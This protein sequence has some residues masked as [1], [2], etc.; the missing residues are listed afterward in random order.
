MVGCTAVQDSAP[1]AVV[2]A[3]ER[4]PDIFMVT[5]D[6]TNSA[7]LGSE[8]AQS[9]TPNLDQLFGESVIMPNTLTVRGITVISMPSFLSGFYPRTTKARGDVTKAWN[10]TV[11]LIQERLRQV[12]YQTFGFSS[13]FCT[14]IDFGMD[15]TGCTADPGSAYLTEEQVDGDRSLVDGL[16]SALDQREPNKPV[17]AWIHLILP[18]DQY[19]RLEPWYSILHPEPYLGQFDPGNLGRLEKRMLEREPLDAEERRELDAWYQSGLGQT[20]AHIGRLLLGLKERKLYNDAII[21]FGSDHGEELARRDDQPYFLHGC[22]PYNDVM[23]VTWSIRAPELSP[24][25]LGAWVS[26]TDIVPTLL[27]LAH[28]PWTGDAAEGRSLVPLLRQESTNVVPIYAERTTTAAMVIYKDY[29]YLLNPDGDF[30]GCSPYQEDGSGYLSPS[31]GLWDLKTDPG[32]LQNLSGQGKAEE[33]ELRKI[34]CAWVTT[35]GWTGGGG[36]NSTLKDDC[37]NR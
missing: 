3:P 6:A 16:L 5:T 28:V 34:L 10:Q 11:P 9:T 23:R 29:K 26:S 36:P 8:A 18:H 20:D 32:E 33:A 27:D 21:A 2:N 17:F 1:P 24:N 31:Y 35:P 15:T 13:N 37:T 30:T 22:S 19:D 4:L 25:R 12:G 7:Y 14:Y